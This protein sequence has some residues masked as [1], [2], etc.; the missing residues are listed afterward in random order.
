MTASSPRKKHRVFLWVFLAVQALF[1]IWI[2]TG[3]T[4]SAPP[5]HDLTTRA[6]ADVADTGHGIAVVLQVVAWVVADFLL[7]VTW[8]V[9]RF[10]EQ[11]R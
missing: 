4:A 2:I 11:P 6:C 7:A 1:L 10:Q 8:L 5:C 3:A 9:V